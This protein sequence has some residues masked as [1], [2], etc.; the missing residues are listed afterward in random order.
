MT[1][2]QILDAAKNNL[3]AASD[4]LWS[5][6]ELLTH[7][8]L[9]QEEL[10]QDTRCIEN[11][12]TSNIV[13]GTA[14]YTYPTRAM[15]I[16]R[17]TYN[18]AKLQKLDHRQFDAINPNNLLASGTPYYY[19][20]FDDTITLYPTPS[21]SVTDGLK[22]FFYAEPDVTVSGSTLEVPTRYHFALVDGV[23]AR[24]CPKDLGNPETMYWAQK[25]ETAKV[26][27]RSHI[28]TR[29]RSDRFAIVKTEEMS[30]N[31]DFGV[32]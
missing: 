10:A 23:T 14:D 28:R 31:S 15:E 19:L 27:V 20:D 30:L 3:N 24:M 16:W 18:G 6:G 17:I 2:T 22:F 7:L 8:Y 21:A 25:W 26:K 9:C 11:T 13:A 4:S 12:A 32:I 29:R 1:P 5:D